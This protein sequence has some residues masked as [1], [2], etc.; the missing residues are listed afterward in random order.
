MERHRGKHI[1]SD[2]KWIYGKRRTRVKAKNMNMNTEVGEVL[3]Q[4]GQ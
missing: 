2:K 4:R 3:F 1:V